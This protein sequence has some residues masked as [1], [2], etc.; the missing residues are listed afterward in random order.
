MKSALFW[1]IIYCRV[2]ISYR[3]TALWCMISQKSANLIYIT[4]EAR[5]HAKKMHS[6]MLI[7][8]WGQHFSL[9]EW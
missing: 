3:I 9:C 1:D 2:A 5:Y 7:I 4:A 6:G 8:R